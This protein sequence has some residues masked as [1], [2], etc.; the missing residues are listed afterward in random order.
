[1]TKFDYVIL[2]LY[3]F[4]VSQEIAA[5]AAALDPINFLL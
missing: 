2:Y 4:T 5:T 1:M 3:K